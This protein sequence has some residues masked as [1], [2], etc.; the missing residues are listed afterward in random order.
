MS[1]PLVEIDIG[2]FAYQVGIAATDTLNFGQGVHDL[3]L[4][5]DIGVEK[6]ELGKRDWSISNLKKNHLRVTL[7]LCC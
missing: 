7:M 5:V 2:L 4:A 3:L 1:V 6:T